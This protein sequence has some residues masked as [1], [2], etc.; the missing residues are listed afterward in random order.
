MPS[1]AANPE[2]SPGLDAE[3]SAPE[4][5]AQAKAPT[6]ENRFGPVLDV[7]LRVAVHLGK[8]RMPVRSALALKPAMVVRL[9]RSAGE[10]VDL[11]LDGVRIGGGE[12]V[13]IDELMGLRIT[14]LSQ[15]APLEAEKDDA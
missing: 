14:D 2:P 1:A 9:K 13:V 3:P 11:L 8:L 15:E 7:P 4:P 6:A 12:I 10:K 5:A